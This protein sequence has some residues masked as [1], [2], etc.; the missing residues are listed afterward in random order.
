MTD[1]RKRELGQFLRARRARVDRSTFGLPPTT[2]SRQVGLRREEV[3]AF[4]GVSVTWLTWL[5]QGRDINASRQVLEA[6]ARVLSLDPGESTFLLTL[7]GFAAAKPVPPSTPAAVPAHLQRLLDA[8]AFPA[9][10]VA[11]DWTIAGWNRPYSRLYSAIE[12]TPVADRN[13][14]WLLFTDPELRRMMMNWRET[15]KHFVAEFRAEAGLRLG[16]G[17][18]A[19]LVRRLSETSP[20]F[21]EIWR[22]H[23]VERFASR[24]RLFDHPVMGML[25]FEHHR[26]VPSDFPE[27]HLV[28]YLP[29]P[30][31]LTEQRFLKP[32]AGAC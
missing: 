31:T 19:E 29:S 13:L 12:S 9:F 6:L 23:D 25:E 2:R 28:M 1:D 4:A 3:A 32:G 26:M 30:N 20:E 11:A 8:V 21:L 22:N 17:G 10:A 24:Q 18:H 7:G 16:S 14:L 27:L 15:S 5:E